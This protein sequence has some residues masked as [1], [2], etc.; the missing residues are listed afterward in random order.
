MLLF[1]M[2]EKTKSASKSN[3]LEQYKTQEMADENRI[4]P[5][6]RPGTKHLSLSTILHNQHYRIAHTCG[7]FINS[8]LSACE[9]NYCAYISCSRR[10][11]N[12][13]R[14][15]HAITLDFGGCVIFGNGICYAYMA[16][17]MFHKLFDYAKF[18]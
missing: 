3:Q 11:G 15:C 5:D 10:M 16:E 2:F 8:V 14:L 13:P 9:F 6:T 7:R 17:I 12:R 1:K 18:S 4:K